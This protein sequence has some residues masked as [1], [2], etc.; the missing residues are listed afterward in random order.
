VATTSNW[1]MAM[2]STSR[3]Q[4]AGQRWS[5]VADTEKKPPLSA[6]RAP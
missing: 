3:K 1:S 4:P 2:V 5:G 6:T